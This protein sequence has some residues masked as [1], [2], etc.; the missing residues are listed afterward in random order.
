ME[1]L[2]QGQI[3]IYQGFTFTKTVTAEC[4]EHFLT[5]SSVDEKIVCVCTHMGAYTRTDMHAHG[6]INTSVKKADHDQC[7]HVCDSIALRE[8][9]TS[10]H[11]SK[12]LIRSVSVMCYRWGPLQQAF[13]SRHKI[14]TVD[15]TWPDWSRNLREHWLR[16][17]QKK[18]CVSPGQ[19]TLTVHQY[20]SRCAVGK[21]AQVLPY[22]ASHLPSISLILK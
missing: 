22:V 9:E 2:H 15:Q 18:K 10:S 6:H 1:C 16:D 14:H 17:L 13:T 5:R 4:L 21:D 7:F 3:F 8:R 11:M 12:L 20:I 19:K